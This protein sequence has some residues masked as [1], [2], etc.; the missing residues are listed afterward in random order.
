MSDKIILPS[1][2]A[3]I[4]FP[5]LGASATLFAQSDDEALAV[6][7]PGGG[8]YSRTIDSSSDLA[9]AFFDQGLRMAWG[10][11]FP[12]SIASYQEAS[13]LDPTNP[14]PYWG[15]AHAAGPNPNSR[16]VNLPDDPQG[17]GLAAIRK[18]LELAVNGSQLEQDLINATF[19][20]Y[21]RDAI[22]DRRERDFA[23]LAAMR[24][25]HSQYPEDADIAAYLA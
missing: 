22:P 23:F 14:M 9:Q 15:V 21:N 4:L 18:A 19:V 1:F 7:V 2:L 16:Y 10:F 12:E 17:A 20:L 11:Y 6:L 3:L 24:D 13:R 25:L 8:T 5:L